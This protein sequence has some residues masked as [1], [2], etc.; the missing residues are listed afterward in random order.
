MQVVHIKH[1]TYTLDKGYLNYD[2]TIYEIKKKICLHLQDIAIE[3]LYM[4]GIIHMTFHN[5]TIFS[6]LTQ[7]NVNTIDKVLFISFLSN[8]VGENVY[9]IPAKDVYT[10][11]DV[12]SLQLHGKLISYKIPLGIKHNI[13]SSYAVVTT[14]Y[15]VIQYGSFLEKNAKDITS[16]ENLKCLL[17]YGTLVDNTIYVST[18]Q[19]IY[20]EHEQQKLSIP[21]MMK[22]YFPML[23]SKGIFTLPSQALH[24]KMIEDT[25]SSFNEHREKRIQLFHEIYENRDNEITYDAK[26]VS[27]F[28]I[29][30]HPIVSVEFPLDIILKLLHANRD[31]PFI[32]YNPGHMQENIYKV[33]MEHG[34]PYLKKMLITRYRTE[35]SRKRSVG[36]VF[37]QEHYDIYCEIYGDLTISYQYIHTSSGILRDVQYIKDNIF[38]SIHEYMQPI[39]SFLKKED[40]PFTLFSSF[41]DNEV[42]ILRTKYTAIVTLDSLLQTKKFEKY[43]KPFFWTY[44]FI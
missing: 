16:T 30:I 6:M 3:E 8:I 12:K 36:F 43:K 14:P 1:D 33:F 41:Y 32:K 4:F 28:H 42:E 11:E 17:E 37:H 10:Y 22:L 7:D 31:V 26:G 23:W 27:L 29:H 9:S 2:D 38:P 15:D 21:T 39:Y 24:L 40:I 13:R 20:N 44:V 19:D 5:D 34:N 25:V 18:I 35:L